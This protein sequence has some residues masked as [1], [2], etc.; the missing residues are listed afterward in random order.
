VRT[1]ATLAA[2]AALAVA[3]VAPAALASDRHPTLAEIE[4]E[5]MC[6]VC[7]TTLD[8]SDSAFANQERTLIRSLIARGYTKSQIKKKLVAEYGPEILAAPPDSGFNVLAWW[9]PIAG[10]VAGA[11]A[12]GWLAWRWSRGRRAPPA[13]ASASAPA[14]IE[15]ELEQRLDEELARFDA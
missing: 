3:A 8:Q 14:K 4:P 2:A 1:L 12:I 11:L 15:P 9:L 13:D 5:V 7:K 10:V 6:L